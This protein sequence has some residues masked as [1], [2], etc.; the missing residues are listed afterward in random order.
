MKVLLVLLLLLALL[1]VQAFEMR[2][3]KMVMEDDL[4]R[5]YVLTTNHSEKVVLDCQSFIQGLRLG[6]FENAF[7]YLMDSQECEG[8]QKRIKKSLRKSQD[9]CL[10][11]ED[12]V[13]RDDYPC[14]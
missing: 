12:V 4:E 6:E 1:D 7:T 8:L 2:V 14:P 9:Y 11:L 10:D 3:R 5:S 13:M